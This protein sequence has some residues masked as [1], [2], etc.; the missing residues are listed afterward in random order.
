MELLCTALEDFTMRI[1]MVAA[2]VSIII[3]CSTADSS[4]LATAWVEGFAILVAVA[5]CTNVTA[6]NDYQKERQF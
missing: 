1:L 5:V 6:F 3:D 4:H 2:V